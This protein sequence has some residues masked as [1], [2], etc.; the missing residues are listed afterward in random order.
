MPPLPL[1]V[2][3]HAA[4]LMEMIPADIQDTPAGVVGTVAAAKVL[5]MVQALAHVARRDVASMAPAAAMA[6]TAGVVELFEAQLLVSRESTVASTE[7]PAAED[8]DKARMQIQAG[9]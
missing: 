5:Q 7:V 2:A 4:V 3:A 1:A 8:L 6:R 9:H